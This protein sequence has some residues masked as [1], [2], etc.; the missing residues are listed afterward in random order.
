MASFLRIYRCAKEISISK[1]V[2]IWLS[3]HCGFAHK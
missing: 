1:F 2:F 3:T